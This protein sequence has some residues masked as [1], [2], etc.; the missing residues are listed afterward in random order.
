[1]SRT[2]GRRTGSAAKTFKPP[3]E[4]AKDYETVALVLQGGG[5]LGAYQAGVYE[6]LHDAGIRPNWIAG[7]SIG[8]INA[9][10]IAGNPPERRVERLRTFWDR[11][12][13]SAI[14]PL[15]SSLMEYTS[16]FRP[17]DPTLRS[18]ANMHS[19]LR[20]I[21]EGQ[22][23]FFTPRIPSPWLQPAGSEGATSF[24]DNSPLRAT[25]AELIDFDLLNSATVRISLGAVDVATGNLSYFE[26]GTTPL[27]PEHVMASGALPPG[28]PAV[29]IDGH[30]YWDGGVVWNTPLSHVLSTRPRRDTLALQVDLWSARGPVPR[31]I[32]DVLTRQKDIQYSSRTRAITN[33]E[34]RL[35]KLRRLV[36]RLLDQLPPEIAADDAALE[37]RE[38]ACS[39]VFNIIHLI[40]RSKPYELSSKDYEFGF[41]SMR[42]HW[43]SGFDD[44]QRTLEHRHYFAR[45]RVEVGVVTHD[46]HREDRGEPGARHVAIADGRD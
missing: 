15:P 34:A 46:V 2:N 22:Q 24:Y 32:G 23:G 14:L 43:Q 31:H 4:A 3:A 16:Q 41:A 37:L 26:S 19:A 21:V 11:V 12:S 29:E 39:K 40:Y 20:A 18:L 13:S 6:A 9:A 1:M 10:L 42:D 25:L 5:A 44:M 38:F 28:F 30:A 17:G 36:G 33:I 27:R 35:Q 45:P 8:A 7:I